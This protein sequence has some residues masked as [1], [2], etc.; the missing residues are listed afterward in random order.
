VLHTL[1]LDQGH[2]TRPGVRRARQV[3]DH[4]PILSLDLERN[5]RVFSMVSTPRLSVIDLM[6]V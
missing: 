4:P 3:H 6:K 2:R 5:L 1:R